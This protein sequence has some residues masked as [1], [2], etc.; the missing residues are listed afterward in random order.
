MILPRIRFIVIS[1][2]ILVVALVGVACAPKPTKATTFYSLWSNSDIPVTVA[3]EDFNSVELGLKFKTSV[4]GHITAIKFYK[5]AE[6]TGEHKGT[7]WNANKE[8]LESVAFTSESNSGWQTATF[9]KP[10]KIDANSV[11]TASYLA[12]NGKYAATNDY[13]TTPRVNGPVTAL[14][15][16]NGVYS[17][18]T[19][20]FPEN[21]WKSSNYWVDVVFSPSVPDDSTNVAISPSDGGS[22]PYKGLINSTRVPLAVWFEG[23]GTQAEINKDKAAGLNTYVE[24]TTGSNPQLIQDNDMDLLHSNK[25]W[26]VGDGYV[27]G[28]EVDMWAGPGYDTWTGNYP[29]QGNVCEPVNGNCGYSVLDEMVNYFPADN[30]LR[31]S[32]YGKGV[33]FW[34][35]PEQAA[36]F[37]NEYQDL[38]SVDNYWFTDNNLCENAEGP[39]IIQGSG[40][41]SPY[42]GKN[43]L[44]Q[45]ECHRAY[46]YGITTSV[47]RSKVDPAG[48]KPVWNLV[49]V[50]GPLGYNTIDTFIQPR[51][52]DAAVWHSLIAGARGIIYF[53]H[54]FASNTDCESQHVLREDYRTECNYDK[55]RNQVTATNAKVQSVASA[56]NG[57]FADFNGLAQGQLNMSG[58]V[59]ASARWDGVNFWLLSGSTKGRG[60]GSTD[61]TFTLPCLDGASASV[62]GENRNVSVVNNVLSDNFADELTTHIYKFNDLGTCTP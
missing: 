23:T 32:N 1:I 40:P 34:N 10:V 56:I 42:T 46:N 28:D 33:M 11:Y 3:A 43:N 55:V 57:N 17:Y 5:N 41:V 7:L 49:E 38:V 24:L 31:Y 45:A 60:Q 59:T 61:A 50:G 25:N 29:G 44:T 9:D 4:P 15:G 6:N 12:P 54:T 58:D 20:A 19:G 53:N 35:N 21:S 27:L 13:F 14:A 2:A 51:E 16:D 47:L 48:S 8:S 26:S 22:E 39:M 36:K 37:V 62:V 30:K 52:I 18:G